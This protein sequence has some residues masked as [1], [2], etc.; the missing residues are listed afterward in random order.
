MKT[1]ALLIT[2]AIGLA[3][4]SGQLLFK[5]RIPI[6]ASATNIQDIELIKM[7]FS[8]QVTPLYTINL[9]AI[10]YSEDYF[11]LFSPVYTIPDP[12]ARADEISYSSNENCFRQM[13]M[14]ANDLYKEKIYIWEQFRCQQINQLP[15]WFFEDAPFLHPS[16]FSYAYLAYLSNHVTFRAPEWIRKNFTKFHITELREIKEVRSFIQGPLE[17]LI[18]L[19]DLELRELA[20]GRPTLLTKDYLIARTNYGRGP[21]DDLEYRIYWRD[22]LDIFLKDTPFSVEQYRVGKKCFW[23]DGPLCWS[24]NTGAIVGL[25]NTPSL[26]VFGTS[27]LCLS[28]V[29]LLLYNKIKE[30]RMEEE[31]KRIALSVLTHEFR[32]PVASLMLEV[33]HMQENFNELPTYVQDSFLR[34][35]SNIHRLKRLTEG[36]KNYLKAKDLQ[37]LIAVKNEKIFSVNEYLHSIVT[38]Y[39]VEFIPLE[40]DQRFHVDSFWLGICIKNLIENAIAHGKKPVTVRAD[41]RPIEEQL[42]IQVEDNGQC[43]FENIEKLTQEFV[44]GPNSTG[45]G[46]GLNIVSKVVKELGGKLI[47]EKN[48]T[49]FSILLQDKINH[50]KNPTNNNKEV[51]GQNIIS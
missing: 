7:E 45:M 24:P 37:K 5:L 19:E 44:K 15:E 49:R 35:S 34:I 28:L 11:R 1:F 21:F 20:S 40:V 18:T 17:Y 47:F 39:D 36:S 22:E 41:F 33:E 16:G 25:L 50:N 2:I 43:N 8:K 26:I 6:D 12:K 3:F 38:D 30:G 13:P 31:Q 51:Y 10:F 48:P 42:R 4:F 14:F 46:L 27:I 23:R 32:T 29:L 9:H